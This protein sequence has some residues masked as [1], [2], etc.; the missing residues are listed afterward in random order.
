MSIIFDLL[1]MGSLLIPEALSN[2]SAITLCILVSQTSV[3]FQVAECHAAGEGSRLKLHIPY[4]V[5]QGIHKGLV[6]L[7]HLHDGKIGNKVDQ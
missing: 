2:H 1:E 6:R 5:S 4:A 7:A 3:H